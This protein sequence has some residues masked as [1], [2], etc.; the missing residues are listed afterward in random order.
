MASASPARMIADDATA[1]AAGRELERGVKERVGVT[2]RAEVVA[3]HALERSLGKAKRIADER[4]R[5]A[6]TGE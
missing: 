4:R 2:V 6:A 5:P 3:P 1:Q